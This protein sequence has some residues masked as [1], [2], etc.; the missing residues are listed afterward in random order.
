MESGSRK[1]SLNYDRCMIYTVENR[2]THT[3][4]DVNALEI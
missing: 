3:D 2:C 4:D 1:Q